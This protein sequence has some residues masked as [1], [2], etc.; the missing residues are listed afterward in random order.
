MTARLFGT[1]GIRGIVGRD[2]T[3]DL[4]VRVGKSLGAF[5]GRGPIALARD[6]RLSGPMLA[7]AAASGLMA[8]GCDV[9]DLGVVPTPAAQHYVAKVGGLKGA[10]V[11][12]ASHNPREYNGIKAIDAL[13][14]EMRRS[15]E[16]AVEAIYFENRFP[17]TSWSE[18]GSFRSDDTA[19]LRYLNA[20][21]SRVD[22][23]AIRARG[24]RVVVDPGNGAGALTT[25]YLLR[26]LGC[27]VLS[28]NGQPDGAFPGRAPE[29]V[30]EHLGDLVRMTKD[31]GADLGVAHDGDGDRMVAVDDRGR[32]V[33][34]DRLLPLFAKVHARKA[35]VVP[36]DAS[37]VLDDLL[38]GV[39][40]HRTRVGD[41]FVGQELKRLGADFG[42]EPSGTWI[43]PRETLCPDGPLA[44][45]I[46][47]G[48][49]QSRGRP[50]SEMLDNLPEYP[51]LREA[52]RFVADQ[53]LAVKEALDRAFAGLDAEVTRVDGWRAAFPDGWFVVRLS[54]TE[55][56]VRIT[57]EARERV[58]AEEL[59]EKGRALVHAAVST[60]K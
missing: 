47:V 38:P 1:N 51:I 55:P 49:V 4:A 5:L 23:E 3:A 32:Y 60:A 21:L 14:L 10:V 7:R 18:V 48:L 52:H 39:A 45:A 34:G 36:V 22:V 31:A 56:K 20:I 15:D 44:A 24:F 25:P 12:T 40:V 19:I 58:R 27:T 41:V 6:T 54:G 37:M 57:A 33:G 13:G 17:E 29:P 26:A 53:R 8:V 42:G 16:E 46:L 35:I 50:L 43:F 59:L 11:V 9:V 30:P 2:M 28:L